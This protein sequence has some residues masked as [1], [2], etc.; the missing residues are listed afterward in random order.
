MG[1]SEQ[2]FMERLVDEEI[3]RLVTDAIKDG[4]VISTSKCVA[5]VRRAYVACGLSETEIANRVIITA[6]SAG[7][8]VQIDQTSSF[9]RSA[10]VADHG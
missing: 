9:D 1:T 4:G 5:E 7:V 10:I 3:R 2:G 6:T 8:A